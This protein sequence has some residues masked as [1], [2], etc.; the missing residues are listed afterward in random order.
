VGEAEPRVPWP[1][2]TPRRW[3]WAAL[4]GGAAA[5][6]LV[7][8]ADPQVRGVLGRQLAAG[9]FSVLTARTALLALSVAAE[10]LPDL[11]VL[12]LD[13]PDLDGVEVIAGLRGWSTLPIIVLSARAG[14]D[15]KVEAFDAGADDYVTKPFVMAE[16]L[17]RVR[18]AARRLASPV[19]AVAVETE[20]FTVDLVGKRVVKDGVDVHLTPNEWG[21]LELLVRNPGRLIAQRQI[22]QQVWGPDRVEASHYLRVY[23]GQLRRKLERVPSRPRHL[24]TEP[25]MGYRFEP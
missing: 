2:S 3:Q 11:L 19:E 15:D 9:G 4:P 21:V 23:L 13:L 24:L 7:A 25:G 5:T 6:V 8:D 12:D 18:A 20:A 10:D 22:L 1:R 17:A 16:L 14:S